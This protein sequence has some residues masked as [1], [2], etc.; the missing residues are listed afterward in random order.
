MMHPASYF[1]RF[2]S[3]QCHMTVLVTLVSSNHNYSID[4]TECITFS[5]LVCITSFTIF[6]RLASLTGFIG[7]TGFNRF[8]SYTSF[9]ILKCQSLFVSLWRRCWSQSPGRLQIV[10]LPLKGGDWVEEEMGLMGPTSICRC[11]TCHFLQNSNQ[12]CEL[13]HFIVDG[14]CQ[15]HCRHCLFVNL[16]I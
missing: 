3:F 9:T 15:L 14:F 10:V 16:S 12:R 1:L 11:P 13:C 6:T 2:Y 5:L 4:V 7:F 8:S